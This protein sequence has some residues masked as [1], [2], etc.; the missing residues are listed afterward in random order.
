MEERNNT[1]LLIDGINIGDQDIVLEALR[2]YITVELH[3]TGC[4]TQAKISEPNK[5]C[6]S[7]CRCVEG[8]IIGGGVGGGK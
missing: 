8:E 4:I 3:D 2:V 1:S 6:C 7:N 5:V